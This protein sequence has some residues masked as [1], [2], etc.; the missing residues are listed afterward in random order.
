MVFNDNSLLQETWCVYYTHLID[1]EA[2]IFE[3]LNNF[4]NV[5][6]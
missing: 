2:N 6:L 1:E 5:T 4:S 3:E